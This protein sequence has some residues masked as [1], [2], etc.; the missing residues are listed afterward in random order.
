MAREEQLSVL[1]FQS[2]WMWLP[3]PTLN[4]SQRTETASPQCPSH[5]SWPLWAP[6]HTWHT[7][8]CDLH[9]SELPHTD[10]FLNLKQNRNMLKEKNKAFQRACAGFSRDHYISKGCQQNTPNLLVFLYTHTAFQGSY[11]HCQPLN[12]WVIPPSSPPTKYCEEMQS[13]TVRSHRISS[14]KPGGVVT[15]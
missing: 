8:R 3:A 14:F 11:I 6:A 12:H 4:G 9:M 1:L 2:T 13:P 10:K 7:D 5:A 15:L